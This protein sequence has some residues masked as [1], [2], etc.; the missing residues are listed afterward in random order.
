MN[1]FDTIRVTIPLKKKFVVSK[2]EAVTKTNVI[3]ILNNRYNGEASTSVH[4]GPSL[5]QIEIELHD[6]TQKLKSKHM[7]DLATLKEIDEY[8]I[9]PVTKSALIGMVLNYISGE[10][11]RYPW[12]VL[13]L[14]TPVGIKSSMTIGLDD[15]AKMAQAIQETEFPIVKVK[16]G[17]Q[18]DMDLVAALQD[19]SGKEVRVDANGGWTCEQAEEMIYYLA[20]LGVRIIE[21]PTAIES[22]SEWKR[23]KGK[24]ADI[25]LIADEGLNNRDDYQNLQDHIDGINIKM[26]K[27]GGIL[28]AVLLA[29]QAHQDEK[30]VMLGC[31]VESSIGIAQAIY[32]SSLADYHDLD[33]PL[34][35]E[36]DIAQ[37]ITYTRDTIEV[38]REIIG[39]PK[40]KRDVVEKYSDR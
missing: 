19:I 35:L 1:H 3:T 4:Y 31:M 40:L 15:P 24:H 8:D 38:D 36:N 10:T 11:A 28:E 29:E 7:I 12:E 9:H 22:V 16:M 26:E 37:G 13:S 39:G 23:L 21:Q 2:G 14:S 30:K 5:D 18:T 33:A 25:E 20:G 17:G 27:S 32:M 6:V 34:L